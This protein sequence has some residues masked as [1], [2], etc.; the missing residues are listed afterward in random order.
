MVLKL[1]T[2]PIDEPVSLVDVKAHLRIDH[3]DDDALLSIY[4][5]A[6]TLHVDGRNGTLQRALMPQTWELTLDEFPCGAIEIPLPPLA[7]ITS[8]VYDDSDGNEQTIDPA[9]YYVD[10]VSEPG[11]VV[12]IASYSWPTPISAANAV[13]VRFVA[14]YQEVDS[15][16]NGVPKPLIGAI[17]LMVGDMYDN[18]ESVT[19]QNVNKITIPTAVDLLLNQYRIHAFA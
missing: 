15:V 16:D 18:R 17:L 19:A 14:G 11:W 13:R 12:P 2:A 10:T 4:V 9:N 3:S 7:E 6:A 1:I 5:A 8:V